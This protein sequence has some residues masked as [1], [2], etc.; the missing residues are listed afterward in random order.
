M[1][2][3]WFTF[4]EYTFGRTDGDGLNVCADSRGWLDR[5]VGSGISRLAGRTQRAG[6]STC[7]KVVRRVPLDTKRLRDA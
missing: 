5:L 2:I 7:W 3:A 6:R 4:L 1:A